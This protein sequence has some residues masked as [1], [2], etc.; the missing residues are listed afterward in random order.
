MSIEKDFL[1]ANLEFKMDILSFKFATLQDIIR[2]DNLNDSFEKL[3]DISKNYIKKDNAEID[4]E[5][6]K[7]I[8]QEVDGILKT[9]Y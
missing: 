7:L 8:N 4:I 1:K 6:L 3:Y 9:L 2:N 5:I